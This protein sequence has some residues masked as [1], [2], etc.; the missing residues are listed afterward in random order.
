MVPHAAGPPLLSGKRK[1]NTTGARIRQVVT[2]TIVRIERNISND[3][4]KKKLKLATSV[5]RRKSRKK[6]I[7]PANERTGGRTRAH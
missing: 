7:D 4:K 3:I 2:T 6:S 5:A 1:R